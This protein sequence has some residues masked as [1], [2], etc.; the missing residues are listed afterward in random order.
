MVDQPGVL[1]ELKTTASVDS[2]AWPSPSQATLMAAQQ[3][4]LSLIT[5]LNSPNWHHLYF[6]EHA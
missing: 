3:N 5:R 1:L 2:L 6:G 4:L